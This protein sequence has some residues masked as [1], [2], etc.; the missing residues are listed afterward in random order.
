MKVPAWL[1]RRDGLIIMCFV[2]IVTLAILSFLFLNRPVP[3]VIVAEGEMGGGKG[4]VPIMLAIRG[5][6]PNRTVP[7]GLP[8]KA[9][10]ALQ[11]ILAKSDPSLYAIIYVGLQDGTGHRLRINSIRVRRGL[12]GEELVV[13]YSMDRPSP[14]TVMTHP[15]VIARVDTN[16]RATDV[17]F[18]RQ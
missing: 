11:E 10:T 9:K 14:E 6:D 15:F 13:Q 2:A 16:M 12:W 18:E 3:F 17:V 5:D 7:D 1:Q 4:R 8:D